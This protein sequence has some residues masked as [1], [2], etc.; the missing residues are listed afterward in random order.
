MTI[1]DWILAIIAVPG[2]ALFLFAIY[3]T[4]RMREDEIELLARN[5]ER[6]API[7]RGK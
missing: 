2:F 6:P 3:I 5:S 7:E 1:I 4:M